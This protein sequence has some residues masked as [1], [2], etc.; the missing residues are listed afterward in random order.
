MATRQFTRRLLQRRPTVEVVI[1]RLPRAAWS[2]F[3]PFH[4]MSADLSASSK[5]FGIWAN[6]TI[7]G[8]AGILPLPVSTGV[9]KGSAIR[10]VSRVVILPDWQ[11]LGLA[12]VLLDA[13]GAQYRAKGLRFRNYPAHPSFI[14]AHDRSNS[15]ELREKPGR[16][17]A[18]RGWTSRAQGR[19]C[20]VFEYVG[21]PADSAVLV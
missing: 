21:P 7:A 9:N 15:W 11:G 6:G 4:Y 19:P 3:S 16:R 8:F 13:L 17:N 2:L 18:G 5:C 1:G 14:R 20:A 10:R 12:F